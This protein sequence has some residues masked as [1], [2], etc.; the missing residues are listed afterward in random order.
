MYHGD[1]AKLTVGKCLF[2]AGLKPGELDVLNGSPPCQGFSTAGKRILD[3]PRNSL[4]REYV[5]LLRGL[6]PKAFVMENVSGMV[7][8][9]MKLVFT[10]IMRELKA[11]G[12]IVKARVLNA[13]YY[14]V[15]QSRERMIIIGVRE[16]VQVEPEHP[17]GQNYLVIFQ[18]ATSDICHE[19]PDIKFNPG[20]L[21]AKAMKQAKQGESDP[22]HFTTL[23][24]DQNRQCPTL[25]HD[26]LGY[27]H[28]WHPIY[29]RPLN[30]NEWK[31]C[32]SYP[33]S[34]TFTDKINGC[35]RIGNS[36]PPLFARAIAS[37]VRGLLESPP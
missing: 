18:D 14:G 33:D 35:Q 11:S 5:R 31:R 28:Y 21:T 15:P 16:D 36:V 19:A 10:E 6:Q 29:H 32:A 24:L 22:R 4:F 34:F 27:L 12:Y 13:M 20:M 30:L 23:K 17:K 2:L 25:R 37:H 3:D 7:K 1:I 26:F 8:G 9:K